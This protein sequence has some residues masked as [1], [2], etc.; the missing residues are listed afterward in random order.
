VRRLTWTDVCSRRLARHWLAAP[1]DSVTAVAADVCGIHAQVMSAAELALGLRVAGS[2]AADVR[3][4][5]WVH[6]SLVKTFGPRGTVHLFPSEHWGMWSSALSAVPRPSPT[7][8]PGVDLDRMQL[9]T[10]IDAIGTAVVEA[11]LTVDEMDARIGELTGAWACERVYPAFATLWPRWRLALTEAAYRGTV[12]FGPNRGRNVTYTSVHRQVPGYARM[13]GSAALAEVAFRYL[14]TYGPA[15]PGQFARWLGAPGPTAVQVF[16]T[17]GGRITE[18]DVDGRRGWLPVD[19][20]VVS[21]PG[22][23]LRLLPYFDGYTV[24]CHPR[25]LVFPGVASSRALTNGQ[26]GTVAVVL[27]DGVVHGVWHH[28]AAGRRANITVE[29]FSPLSRRHRMDLEAQVE[30]VGGVLGRTPVLTV[31]TVGAGRHL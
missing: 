19:D 29:P 10:V 21:G 6:R 17:L 15:T 26:A 14:R 3:A 12:C 9:E 23:G 24:G 7:F 28:R 30:R 1:S 16:E 11:D 22:G 4:A 5:L 8:G 20:D 25:E 27:I 31:G 2:T 18:V 13:D